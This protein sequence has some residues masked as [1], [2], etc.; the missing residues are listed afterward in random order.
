[1]KNSAFFQEGIYLKDKDNFQVPQISQNISIHLS[2]PILS[3]YRTA[4][5]NSGTPEQELQTWNHSHSECFFCPI[6]EHWR[7]E[8]AQCKDCVWLF[9]THSESGTALRFR[10]TAVCVP[11]PIE[12]LFNRYIQL[13]AWSKAAFA[14]LSTWPTVF[15]ILWCIFYSIIAISHFHSRFLGCLWARIDLLHVISRQ[16]FMHSKNSIAFYFK[17]LQGARKNLPET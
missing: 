3:A 9:H 13:L 2:F 6:P 14:P 4:L 16:L 5:R 1:M 15:L 17:G 7:T 11:P 8:W 10:G 12:C